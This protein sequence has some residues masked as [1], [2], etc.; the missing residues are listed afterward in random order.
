MRADLVVA[1]SWLLVV[2]RPWFYAALS[3]I[4]S[5][6]SMSISCKDLLTFLNLL[7]RYFRS[8]SPSA[9]D[10]QAMMADQATPAVDAAFHVKADNAVT[11]L[12]QYD[13]Y[14]TFPISSILGADTSIDVSYSQVYSD[15]VLILSLRST[16]NPSHTEEED[17][18]SAHPNSGSR[19]VGWSLFHVSS[20]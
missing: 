6:M 10:L 4:L 11:L 16:G 7:G 5:W 18:S 19:S 15:L 3:K 1:Q 12:A 17:C 9:M 13:S 8:L 14:R 20:K 2:V